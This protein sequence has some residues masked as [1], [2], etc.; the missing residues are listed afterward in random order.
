MICWQ[1]GKTSCKEKT[2]LGE[3]KIT[4]SKNSIIKSSGHK[5]EESYHYP[6]LSQNTNLELNL[7]SNT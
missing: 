7:Y 1:M 4:T 2:S 5:Y 6:T 3:F